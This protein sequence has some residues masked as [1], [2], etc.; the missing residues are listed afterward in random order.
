VSNFPLLVRLTASN[1]NFSLPAADGSNVRFTTS[2]GAALD[3]EIERWSQASQVAEIWVKIPSVTANSSTQYIIMNW[4]GTGG[5][6]SNGGNTFRT[7]STYD[8]DL[9]H[10][11]EDYNDST[12]QANHLVNGS[13]PAAATDCVIGKC[14]DFNGSSHYL[15]INNSATL[16][17]GNT[18]TASLWLKYEGGS[19][20]TTFGRVISRKNNYNDNNGWEFSLWNNDT[21][22]QVNTSTTGSSG[23]P[24]SNSFLNAWSSSVWTYVTVHGPGSNRRQ[25][26][27]DRARQRRG[28]QRG[29]FQRQD[30]RSPRP[31]HDRRGVLRAALV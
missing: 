11:M 12:T 21:T 6:T 30:R 13:A 9:V 22:A 3:Y 25:R 17:F 7:T 23:G 16:D 1:F 10:H 26:P 18:F 24:Q 5:T 2:V 28:H 19:A 29:L 14:Y 31:R 4:A 8:W 15:R 20:N 27:G